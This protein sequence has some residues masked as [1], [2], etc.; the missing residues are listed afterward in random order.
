[1]PAAHVTVLP[2]DLESGKVPRRPI[3]SLQK[4]CNPFR[5]LPSLFRIE[6]GNIAG[7]D[8]AGISGLFRARWPARK[9][10]KCQF[11]ISTNGLIAIPHTPFNPISIQLQH[12][13]NET[14]PSNAECGIKGNTAIR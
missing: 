6:S 12:N 10:A 13:E 5:I 4:P 14:F 11:S 1:M 9:P 3:E 8:F 7:L 2:P